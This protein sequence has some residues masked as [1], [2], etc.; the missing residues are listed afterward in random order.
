VSKGVKRL[1][2]ILIVLVTLL[3][4]ADFGVAAAAEYQISKQLKNKL[5]LVDDPSVD[6]HGFPF[7]TQAI[8][9][10]YSDIS[11]QAQGISVQ[12]MKDL[13]IDADLRDVKAPLSDVLSGNTSAI[14]VGELDGQ[15]QIKAGDL[16]RMLNIPDLAIS[17]QPLD[18]IKGT[19]AADKQQQA[20]AK[21]VLD[22]DN[23]GQPMNTA[24]GLE[25]DGTVDLAGQQTKVTVLGT[26]SLSSDGGLTITPAKLSLANS[27]VTGPLA[28]SIENA[29]LPKFA[30]TIGGSKMP[31]PFSI[32]A[33]GV[34]VTSGSLIV[35]GVAH[36][37]S[38]AS[39]S[40]L[41]S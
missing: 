37:V 3:V 17:Q 8:S 24:A 29:L 2:I 26:L 33:T 35:Q 21:N 18:I 22:S 23:G 7:L 10:S 32:R 15:V 36:N 6:I 1:L 27:Q 40:G 20:D 41:S 38:F 25:L 31:L 30:F 28:D 4:A 12:N 9:G 16:G 34:A 14:T 11:V 19:G 5:N 13:E 39:A